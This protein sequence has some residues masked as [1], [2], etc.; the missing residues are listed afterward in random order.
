MSGKNYG[1]C[2][3]CYCEHPAEGHR[4]PRIV[5][6][7]TPCRPTCDGIVC[8]RHFDEIARRDDF[9]DGSPP[10][11]TARA[12]GDA[13]QP[14]C[15]HCKKPVPVPLRGRPRRFCNRVCDAAHVAETNGATRGRT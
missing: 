9:L 7:P 10:S 2:S 12:H 5:P 4:P 1:S 3:C 13:V 6:D 14:R 11:F 8:D 15:A